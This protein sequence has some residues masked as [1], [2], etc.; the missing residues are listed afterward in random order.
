MYRILY[1][2]ANTPK[3]APAI[4]VVLLHITHKPYCHVMAIHGLT[5]DFLQTSTC[6]SDSS[7]VHSSD[8][9]LHPYTEG[10]WSLFLQ[11]V[12][13]EGTISQNAVL[14]SGLHHSVCEQHVGQQNC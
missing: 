3:V 14:H 4:L 1:I 8:T 7:H 6:Y 2:I 5:K 9:K 11:N 13:H 12:L 10:V